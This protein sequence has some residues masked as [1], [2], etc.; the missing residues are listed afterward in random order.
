MG[1]GQ[2]AGSGR[3]AKDKGWKSETEA[4]TNARTSYIR[5]G[6]QLAQEEEEVVWSRKRGGTATVYRTVSGKVVYRLYDTNVFTITSEGAVILDTGEWNTPTTRRC[7]AD[8][9]KEFYDIYVSIY[10]DKGNPDGRNYFSIRCCEGEWE[11]NFD[12]TLLIPADVLPD[13]IPIWED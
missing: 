9:F 2:Y 3:T 10:G 12:Q 13:V 6:E 4:I 11:A 1:F 5:K 8:A 7:M